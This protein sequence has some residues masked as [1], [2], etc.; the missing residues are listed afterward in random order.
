MKKNC[1]ILIYLSCYTSLVKITVSWALSAY[2]RELILSKN[3]QTCSCILT[4]TKHESFTQEM[5]G[6]KCTESDSLREMLQNAEQRILLKKIDSDFE[7]F[8]L[9]PFFVPIKSFS[10]NFM[11][12]FCFISSMRSLGTLENGHF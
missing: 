12:K 3:I 4:T 5:K 1:L 11:T 8:G 7:F 9:N 2:L 10:I 6:S